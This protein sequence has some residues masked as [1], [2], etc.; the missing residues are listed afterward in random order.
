METPPTQER[1]THSATPPSTPPT[2][3]QLTRLRLSALARLFLL[4]TRTI[5]T[6]YGKKEVYSFAQGN[7]LVYLDKD[8][9]TVDVRSPHSS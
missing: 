1:F 8:A 5:K 7:F 9:K 3:V 6:W 4:P 2:L